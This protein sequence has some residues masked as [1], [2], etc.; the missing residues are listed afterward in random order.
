MTIPTFSA[1]ERQIPQRWALEQR[2]LINLMNR[3]ATFF[4]EQYTRPDGTLKWREKWSG[5]DG[6][7]NGYEIFI[8]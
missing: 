6:T 3:T 4:A 1:T 8:P 2:E 5:M 7:D